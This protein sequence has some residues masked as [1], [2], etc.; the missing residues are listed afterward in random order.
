MTEFAEKNP[1]RR[2]HDPA[3][4][5]RARPRRAHLAH[6]PVLAAGR[7]D[8]PRLRPA[9]PVRARGRRGA[10]A[11]ARRSRSA[12]PGVYNVAGDGVLALTEVAGP[13]RQA[14]R[15]DPAAVGHR[16]GRGRAL[17]RLGRAASRP[18][19]STSC[20][21]A[22]GVDNRRYKAAGFDY[23]YTSREAVI[24]LGEHLR[25]HPLLRGAQRALPLRARG[26][27]VPALEPARARRARRAGGAL[28]REQLVE[29]QRLLD[30]VRGRRAGR[31]SRSAARGAAVRGPEPPTTVSGSAR[32]RA[33]AGAARSRAEPG[34]APAG[35]PLRRP[36][37]RG[38]HLAARLAGARRPRRRCASTSAA[39]PAA[40]TRAVGAI[41]S[42]L[43]RR[44]R[45][46]AAAPVPALRNARSRCR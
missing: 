15:A 42:V 21:S 16:P 29:L 28:S 36:R 7:A 27:G 5:Q 19:C 43:A 24:K 26:R 2:G 20:A 46:S 17:R 23:G 37:R 22:A 8:D 44:E 35:R 4:R 9:L 33:G 10:R 18:R 41:D 45:P 14:L 31:A 40:I 13:A 6:R 39:T 12:L 38:G 32:P 3:L 30:G 1:R 11:R 34:R 25:L